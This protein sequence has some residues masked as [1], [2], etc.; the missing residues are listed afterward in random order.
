M[1]YKKGHFRTLFFELEDWLKRRGLNPIHCEFKLTLTKE[2]DARV[3]IFIFHNST[4]CMEVFHKKCTDVINV[5][6]FHWKMGTFMKL[7]HFCFSVSFPE[8]L[9]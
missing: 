1:I 4:L 2:L 5:A 8:H 7:V 9:D 3:N 6:I